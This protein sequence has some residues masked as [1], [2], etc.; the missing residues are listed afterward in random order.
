MRFSVNM[1]SVPF[2]SVECSAIPQS[3]SPFST[4]RICT[5]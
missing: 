5:L 4:A 1:T 3:S 2:P